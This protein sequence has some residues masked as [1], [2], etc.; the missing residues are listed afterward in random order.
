MSLYSVLLKMS[1]RIATGGN[2]DAGKSTFTACLF[3]EKDDGNGAARATLF[4]HQHEKESGRTS[5]VTI[6]EGKIGERH[7]VIGDLP[8]HEKYFKTTISGLTGLMCDYVFIVV[9]ANRGVQPITR[10]HFKCAAVMNLPIIIVITKID[11]TPKKILK[12]TIYKCKQMAKKHQ[13]RCYRVTN[14]DISEGIITGTVSRAV[15]PMINLSC[16]S[17]EGF[18]IFGRLFDKLP[19]WRC[20][21]H[22]A[23]CSIQL[24]SI[25]HVHGVGIVV[26]GVCIQGNMPASTM[27]WLGPFKRGDFRPVRVK[28]IFTED[29]DS[30]VIEAGQ[31]GT[32]ALHCKGL[33]R[34]H[35][36][37]GMVLTTDPEIAAVQE[38]TA[39]IF[40]L[41]HATTI[42][43]GYKPVVHCRT[44][45]R[46]AEIVEM[47]KDVIRSG[48]YAKVKMRF[49]VPVFVL[50]GDHFVFRESKSKGVGKIIEIN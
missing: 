10:E 41:H 38:I 36:S 3:G 15:V 48:D 42:K 39:R 47:N 44:V 46:A 11:L 14:T 28:S 4:T 30:G 27:A 18:D 26:G 25:F 7:V 21:D 22:E 37:K 9:A 40:I 20:Y 1:L 6:R 50:K 32:C 23:A 35:I 31:Y 2:V 34:K 24:E 43:V 12:D 8:G 17:E 33:R 16:V 19:V 49:S 13:R 29:T 45:K 5:S